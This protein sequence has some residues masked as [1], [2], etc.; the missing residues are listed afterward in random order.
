MRSLRLQAGR[1]VLPACLSVLFGAAALAQSVVATI[2]MSGYVG[3]GAVDPAAHLVYLPTGYN[4]T[5]AQVTIVNEKTNT[6]AGYINHLNTEW[7][8]TTAALN[9][10]TGLLYVGAED[11]GLYIVNPKT[12]AVLGNV[13]VDAVSVAVNPLTNMIYV[14]DFYSTLYVIDGATDNIVAS[15]PINGIQNIA[16]N[17]V[18][19]RIYA[20]VPYNPG[21]VAVIDGATDQIVAEPTAGSGLTFD[22]AVDPYRDTF[23][24]ADGNQLSSSGAGTASV[25]NGRTNTLTT[26]V[27]LT[28]LPVT[29]SDDPFTDTIYVSNYDTNAVDIIGG[30][31]NTQIGSI[32]VGQ[33]PQYLTGDPINKLLYVGC[34][35][36]GV[37]GVNGGLATYSVV[38]VKTR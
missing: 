26:A 36:P 33:E 28:G 2:P 10:K 23:Y 29:V 8:T 3:S 16:V 1:L 35:T 20:A 37:Q 22:V 25:F 9:L 27:S 14:S 13:N 12:G 38:V 32:A 21:K 4:G 18:N 5:Y 7:Q 11:A 19:N 6:I 31:T 17:P 15:I 24:S 34:E 30:A